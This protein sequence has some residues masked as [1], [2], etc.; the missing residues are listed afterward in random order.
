MLRIDAAWTGTQP[1]RVARV[2]SSAG[3][4]CLNV[5][6]SSFWPMLKNS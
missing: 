2:S 3:S 1:S 6:S 5:A 4:W